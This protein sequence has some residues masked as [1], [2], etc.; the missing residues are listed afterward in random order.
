VTP[1]L[2]TLLVG[3]TV[4]LAA[5]VRDQ[6][7]RVM[8]GRTIAWSSA[9][10]AVAT[11]ANDGLVTAVAGGPASV[12]AAVESKADTAAVTVN[13]APLPAASCTDCLEILPGSL[14]LG[15][16]GAQQ[17]LVAYLV[18]GAGNRTPATATFTSSKPGIVSVADGR[19]TAVALGSAQITAQASGRT[20]AP[21]AAIV[22]TPVTGAILMPDDR[23]Q[24]GPQPVDPAAPFGI[25]YRYTIRV[26]GPP[27]AVG[28]M[29]A[30]TGTHPILGK[31][32]RVTALGGG[33]TE[34]ELQVRPV[35]EV[36]PDFTFNETWQLGEPAPGA[37]VSPRRSPARRAV[38]PLIQRPLEDG[39]FRLGPFTCKPDIEGTFTIALN[40]L[41]ETLEL[42][43]NLSANL[44][45]LNGALSGF[46]VSG[47]LRPKL[48]LTPQVQAALAA[49][50]TCKVIL[51][52]FDVPVSGLLAV[53][54]SP[55]IPVGVGFKF[56]GTV[57]AQVGARI[58][59]Q[60]LIRMTAAMVCI[61][62]RGR[63]H[64]RTTRTPRS[65]GSS[66]RSREGQRRDR[67]TWSG[68]SLPS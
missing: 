53:V 58:G 33:L 56:G 37:R 22:A 15:S 52:E 8:A 54:I 10:T 44:I 7:G 41:V 42:N 21:I 9:N 29:M 66:S 49:S 1:A 13:A 19:A 57:P 62:F 63:A 68:A 40:A 27:P 39:E 32:E 11:V 55:E 65:T 18:D 51:E 61:Q 17:P 4:R 25:G 50:V 26:S 45:F 64:R 46:T 24:R 35:A 5:T 60:G 6:N 43:A 47:E 38:G 31:V 36:L 59:F 16:I 20:S 12:I 67:W 23:V 34:V 30:G 2:A 3:D 28:Q 48:T 14:L